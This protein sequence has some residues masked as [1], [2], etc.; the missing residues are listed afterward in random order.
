MPWLVRTT[1]VLTAFLLA[2]CGS[3]SATESGGGDGGGSTGAPVDGST[4]SSGTDGV[5]GSSGTDG[6]S[7]GPDEGSSGSSSGGDDE[8]SPL[9]HEGCEVVIPAG[10]QTPEAIDIAASIEQEIEDLGRSDDM[11]LLDYGIRLGEGLG[12]ADIYCVSLVL[13]A[14]WFASLET[15]CVQDIDPDIVLEEISEIV[16]GAPTLPEFAPVND[17][18]SA[19]TGCL[20]A[21]EYI[22]CRGTSFTQS[23]FDPNVVRFSTGEKDECTMT[24]SWAIIDAAS[25]ELL[26]CDS[27]SHDICDT[28][29]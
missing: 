18:E 10:E 21:V 29:G 14:E 16:A 20:G 19:P 12:G 1:T 2:A 25:A 9:D 27:D 22:P 17:I 6:D 5:E 8:L 11:T 7:S 26:S 15:N 24:S 13:H 28:E 23:S 4:G 3:D